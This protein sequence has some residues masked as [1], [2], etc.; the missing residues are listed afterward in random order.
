[1]V[2]PPPEPPAAFRASIVV[3]PLAMLAGG[4]VVAHLAGTAAA[5]SSHG[6]WINLSSLS[7][8]IAW[9]VYIACAAGFVWVDGLLVRRLPACTWPSV[10]RMLLG[11]AGAALLGSVAGL[12]GA[13]LL[14]GAVALFGRQGGS[15]EGL[16][17]VAIAAVPLAAIVGLVV[18][19]K[20]RTSARIRL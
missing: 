15:S 11:T 5:E 19:L 2:D 1:V 12:A 8:A 17:F 4:A 6:G 16:L 20:L 3:T 9:M 13:A 18:D 10:G 7:Y 14:G